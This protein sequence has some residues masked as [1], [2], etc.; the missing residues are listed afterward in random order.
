MVIT[1]KAC[2]EDT[3]GAN[4]TEICSSKCGRPHDSCDS[5]TGSC[6]SGCDDGYLGKK[7][8]APCTNNTYGANCSETC[9]P[10]CAGPDDFC[11]SVHGF[12][13]SGCDDGYIGKRC[14]THI[15]KTVVYSLVPVMSAS[16]CLL[17]VFSLRYLH[18]DDFE[19]EEKVLTSKDN[20]TADDPTLSRSQCDGHFRTFLLIL[21]LT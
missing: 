12:C 21:I 3:F 11:D 8:E 15:G 6:I 2:T 16:M 9:S 20:S 5:F 17:L 1:E 10:N 14:Q 13:A 19:S 7:C 18:A 4:C